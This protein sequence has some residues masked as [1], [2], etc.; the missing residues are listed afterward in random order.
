MIR[1]RSWYLLRSWGTPLDAYR[2]LETLVNRVFHTMTLK[3]K[4]DNHW[5]TLRS[6]LEVVIG[7]LLL[8]RWQLFD[9]R[10]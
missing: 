2:G 3:A 10:L 7:E 1:T 9:K 6:I 5:V 8:K 4:D